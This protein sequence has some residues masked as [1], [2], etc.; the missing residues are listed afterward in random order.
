LCAG[1]LKNSWIIEST[2][3]KAP[4]LRNGKCQQLV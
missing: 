2:P 4:S 3:P 1:K